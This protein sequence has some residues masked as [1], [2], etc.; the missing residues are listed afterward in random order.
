MAI[1]MDPAS[2]IATGEAQVEFST[3]ALAEIALELNGSLLLNTPI[4]VIKKVPS[5]P[6]AR[7]HPSGGRGPG[8]P[9]PMGGR[10]GRGPPFPGRG[11]PGAGRG[12]PGAGPPAS[13][14]APAQSL[15]A[16]PPLGGKPKKMVW[17]RPGATPVV[18][19]AAADAAA[20]P[21]ASPAPVTVVPLAAA[22][23]AAVADA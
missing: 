2:G 13:A 23:P 10:G 22:A 16:A 17:V 19:A 8:G 14:G 12:P 1:L 15:A 20:S 5:H 7:P 11:P 9:Y 18:E 21:A 6:A 3:P 4:R